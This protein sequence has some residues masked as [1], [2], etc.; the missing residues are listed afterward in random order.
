MSTTAEFRLSPRQSSLSGITKV[1]DRQSRGRPLRRIELRY[2]TQ[3][4]QP[5]SPS[6]TT[7]AIGALLREQGQAGVQIS[8][9]PVESAIDDALGEHQLRLHFA[10]P[11]APR[12]PQGPTP[13]GW[14]GWMARLGLPLP[15]RKA[16]RQQPT[17]AAQAN[18][19]PHAGPTA[20]QLAASEAAP[21]AQPA[22]SQRQA[23][24]LL[25]RALN[26][27]A[28]AELTL[29]GDRPPRASGCVQAVVV[30]VRQP[31]L[32]EALH[33]LMSGPAAGTSA[34]L[35]RQLL[36]RGLSVA[37]T[38][39]MRYRF[40]PIR[41]DQGTVLAGQDDIDAQLLFE[42]LPAAGPA[43]AEATVASTVDRAAETVVVTAA[44]MPA[45]PSAARANF[46]AL[47]AIAEGHTALPAPRVPRAPRLR[48]TVLGTTAQAYA[49]PFVFDLPLP[50]RLDRASF[51]RA[52]LA[53]QDARALRVLSQSCP[54]L[55]S[56]AAADPGLLLEAATRGSG[57]A[58]QPMYFAED[59][60]G[61]VGK[62]GTG[63]PMTRL[64]INGPEA[65]IDPQGGGLL[66]PLHVELERV[67]G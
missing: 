8:V 59:G 30:T 54:L 37:E 50:A 19:G 38:L 13:G 7:Q 27:A 48:V 15:L 64:H 21:R 60:R 66:Y 56:P 47:P 1:I 52:G 17:G 16:S 46:T 35:R 14:R 31:R 67:A 55:V 62:Q 29:R 63:R 53:T 9:R 34:W 20:A 12:E 58:A 2:S 51:E 36:Q 24:D 44:V 33:A 5:L 26:Q 25:L 41:E 22:L 18:G 28:K 40:E 39:G 49:T 45:E 6:L 23:A 3:A 57:T 11:P 10:E 65:L 42:A 32:H 4:E 43:A 61:I